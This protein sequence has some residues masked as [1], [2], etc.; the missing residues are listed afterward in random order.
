MGC[1]LGAAARHAERMK[2][3]RDGIFSNSNL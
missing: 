2:N 1:G 3:L